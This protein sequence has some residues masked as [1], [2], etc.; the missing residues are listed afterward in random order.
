MHVLI[1]KVTNENMAKGCINY[2][3]IEGESEIIQN[4]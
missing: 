2:I 4:N 3:Q 1:S